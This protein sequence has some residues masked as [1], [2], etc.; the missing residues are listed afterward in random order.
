MIELNSAAQ[1]FL[2]N[3]REP[4]K[5]GSVKSNIGHTE[6]ASALLSVIKIILSFECGLLLPNIHFKKFPAVLDQGLKE[7]YEVF[8]GFVQNLRT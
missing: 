7:K 2:K 5:I 3:R 1:V 6:G 8:G 4:L